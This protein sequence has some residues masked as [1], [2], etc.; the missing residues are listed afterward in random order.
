M[1]VNICYGCGNYFSSE[2]PGIYCSNVCEERAHRKLR[3]PRPHR[4][5]TLSVREAFQNLG[6][7]AGDYDAFHGRMR[8]RT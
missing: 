1:A 5:P 7:V 6:D 2:L 8:K 4:K 3:P